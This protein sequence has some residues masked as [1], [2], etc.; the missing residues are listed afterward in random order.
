[1]E[2]C[3]SYMK[4]VR[5]I[6]NNYLLTDFVINCCHY[7]R[8]GIRTNVL[9]FIQNIAVGNDRY[10]CMKINI[11]LISYS[12]YIWNVELLK[13]SFWLKLFCHSKDNKAKILQLWN[14]LLSCGFCLLMPSVDQV[15]LAHINLHVFPFSFR[16]CMC[17]WFHERKVLQYGIKKRERNKKYDHRNFRW[18]RPVVKTAFLS[19][20]YV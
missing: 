5:S 7:Y 18:H 1:M 12:N 4:Q 11:H 8:T 14:F 6:T 16:W 9:T 19:W 20:S 15:G 13:Y 17:K 2:K 10:I 3:A